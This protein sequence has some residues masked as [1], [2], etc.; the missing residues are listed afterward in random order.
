MTE[1]SIPHV[2][3]IS[4]RGA[5]THNLKRIDLDLPTRQLIVVTGVSGSGKSSLAFD[6]VLSLIHI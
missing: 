5:R 2:R 3:E 1:R 4:V 6:T